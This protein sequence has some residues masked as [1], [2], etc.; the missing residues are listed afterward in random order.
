MPGVR[1]DLGPCVVIWNNAG[2]AE[3]Q[4]TPTF[5]G[6][7]FRDEVLGVDIKRDQEG[8][9]RVDTVT[10]GRIVEVTVPMTQET[11]ARLERAISGSVDS[12]TN[13]KV[14]N[15]AGV[16]VFALSRELL[17][18]PI[19][20]GVPDA[21]S[22]WLHVHRCYPFSNLEWMYDNAGQRFTNVIFRAYPDDETGQVGEM[23]RVG[24]A[25]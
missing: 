11:L 9:T 13:L 6:V 14:S 24:P 22:T 1:K 5:G 18:Q 20:D 15:T 19:E 25:S 17:I 21:T 3:L 12:A 7:Q 23:W 10:T 8:E 4:L 2:V 16:D